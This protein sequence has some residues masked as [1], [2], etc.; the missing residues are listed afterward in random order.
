M[1]P[2]NVTSASST[3]TVAVIGAEVTGAAEA[4]AAN[5]AANKAARGNNKR[6]I[7]VSVGA[8][9]SDVACTL[10]KPPSVAK[11]LTTLTC[12]TVVALGLA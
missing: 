11:K 4:G 2:S 10:R 6:F 1:T 3:V 7:R 12:S 9:Q 8:T 5:T